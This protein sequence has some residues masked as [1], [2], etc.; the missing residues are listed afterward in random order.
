MRNFTFVNPTKIHFGRDIIY[1][2]LNREIPKDKKILITFGGGSVKTNGVYDQVTEA[3]KDYNTLE[4]WGIEPN[5]SYETLIKAVEIVKKEQVD[6]IL[7]V[8]GGSVLDGSKFIAAA[9]CY[10][11]DPWD[12]IMRPALIKSALPLGTVITLPATGS[13]M[14][15]GGVISRKSTHEK[16]AFGSE[17]TFPQFSVLDPQVTYSLPKKQIACGIVDTFAHILEQYLTVTGESMLMD[18]WS[19]GVLQTLIEIGPKAIEN[20]ND[21]DTM[22]N[23]MLCATMGLNGF[24]AMGVTVDWATHMIGHELTALHG[25]T[26]GVTLAII[27]PALMKVMRNEKEDK[28]LQYGERVWGINSGSVQQRIDTTIAKTE[29]FFRSL[30]IAT[31]LKEHGV[32]TESFQTI[33]DRFVERRM[34]LGEGGIVTPEKVLE[35]LNLCK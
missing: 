17:F 4:F 32:G 16:F 23:F 14:N 25:L 29:E 8:G 10:D 28:L 1:K 18:R 26:H 20:Q 2:S 3:L 24:T 27:Y 31:T 30:G 11:G 6:F 12:I 9:S 19:E 35:I 5:P 34:K 21:Y 33:H 22:A 7:A 13:E 15:N